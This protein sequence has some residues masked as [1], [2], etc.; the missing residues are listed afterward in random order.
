[1]KKNKAVI[2]FLLRFFVSYFILSG[3]YQWYLS[4]N[5]QT[6]PAYSCSPITNMVDQHSVFLGNLFGYHF[7]SKQDIT[8]L[9]KDLYVN[10]EFVARIVEGCNSISII[11]L[12]WAFIIAF[13]GKTTKTI[14]YGLIGSL[15]IYGLNI[16]RIVIISIAL[17]KY[18]KYSE[19]LHQIIFPAIIYGF[20][21]LLW[22][23]W[24]KYFAQ[25]KNKN[26]T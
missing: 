6:K 10:D 3:L 21:F 17:Y 23:I 13:K 11:I 7:Y 2:L 25:S 22:V 4:E 26:L 15:L 14:L 12:F 8:E 16:F 9:S 18:P 1:M 19:F 24:V 20:T 5:Q